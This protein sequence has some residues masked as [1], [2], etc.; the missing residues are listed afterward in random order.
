ME[1]PSRPLSHK[2][3]N[4]HPGTWLGDWGECPKCKEIIPIYDNED[5]FDCKECGAKVRLERREG[6]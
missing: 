1:N 6:T 3:L 2:I 5:P 4:Y